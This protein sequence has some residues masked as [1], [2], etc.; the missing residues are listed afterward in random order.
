MLV[1]LT[2]PPMASF[3]PIGGQ[4]VGC[5][6]INLNKK[7]NFYKNSFLVIFGVKFHATAL[8][9]TPT[10]AQK[11]GASLKKNIDAVAS[12]LTPKMFKKLFFRTPQPTKQQIVRSFNHLKTT[13]RWFL[14][15]GRSVGRSSY[16]ILTSKFGFYA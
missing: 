12:N 2:L 1:N 5:E 3:G 6:G 15:V 11:R 16:N 8:A 13:L 7:I 9:C 10:D 4:L 14:V